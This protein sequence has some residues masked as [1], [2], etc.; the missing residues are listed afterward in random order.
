MTTDNAPLN[1]DDGLSK[2]PTVSFN[3][4]Y[5]T[6]QVQL[7]ESKDEKLLEHMREEYSSRLGRAIGRA[8]NWENRLSEDC[9]VITNSLEVYVFT[10]D[11]LE[12]YRKKHELKARIDEV[13]RLDEMIGAPRKITTNNAIMSRIDELKQELEKYGEA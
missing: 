1:A 13:R 7:R 11:E 9:K 5:S 2:S 6:T 4:S 3:V 12:A 10:W 8:K